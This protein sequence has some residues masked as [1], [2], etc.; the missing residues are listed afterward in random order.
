MR[1]VLYVL[2]KHFS[3]LPY[4]LYQACEYALGIHYY[5]RRSTRTIFVC[6]LRSLIFS[7]SR[8]YRLLSRI[9]YICCSVMF[10][11]QYARIKYIIRII[12][13]RFM[14]SSAVFVRAAP[15]HPAAVCALSS[16]F[17]TSAT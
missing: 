6:S 13:C 8:T 3:V 15:V 2:R 12:S 1:A 14:G 10:G 5:M 17:P 7:F 4:V 16:I 9:V 11:K